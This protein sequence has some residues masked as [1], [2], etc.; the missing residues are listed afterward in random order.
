MSPCK[1]PDCLLNKTSSAEGRKDDTG[2]LPLH[3]IP[4][5]A[6]EGIAE[7]L[8]FGATKYAPRN[9]EK[10][11]AW[12][13][14]FGACLRHLWAWWRGEAADAE[15]GK[16]HLLHAGCCILFLIA[17]EIRATGKDDRPGDNSA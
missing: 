6:V 2:K 17:Y 7:I 15:T 11:M 10:G 14:P 3:L 16:S 9:W 5:D 12:S 8:A 13:R 4:Y 1:R